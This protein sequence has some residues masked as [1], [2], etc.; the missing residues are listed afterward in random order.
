MYVWPVSARYP[1]LCLFFTI[2]FSFDIYSQITSHTHTHSV[3]KHS[4]KITAHC[5]TWSHSLLSS[6]LNLWSLKSHLYFSVFFFVLFVA[7]FIMDLFFWSCYDLNKYPSR[8][9]RIA[10]V[11]IGCSFSSFNFWVTLYLMVWIWRKTRWGS[12]DR[13]FLPFSEF[14]WIKSRQLNL[15]FLGLFI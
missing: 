8:I 9:P 1:L 10:F 7:L 2:F 3:Y 12:Y 6:S 14:F 13:S 4:L 15:L 5:S 11:I